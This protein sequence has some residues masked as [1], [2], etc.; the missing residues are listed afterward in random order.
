MIEQMTK[1]STANR[2]DDDQI[3]KKEEKIEMS[4]MFVWYKTLQAKCKKRHA[5]TS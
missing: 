1:E 3:G 2:T 4:S 5:L